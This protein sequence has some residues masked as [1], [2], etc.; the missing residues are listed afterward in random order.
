MCVVLLYS[1]HASILQTSGNSRLPSRLWFTNECRLPVQK[2]KRFLRILHKYPTLFN[3]VRYEKQRAI[4]RKTLKS[5]LRES[6]RRYVHT[7]DTFPA[8]WRTIRYIQGK[9]NSLS[10]P[11]PLKSGDNIIMEIP[12]MTE[13]IQDVF[14]KILLQ[15]TQNK[16]PG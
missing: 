10:V 13:T 15:I 14:Q 16:L 8:E 7:L 1:A 2:R 3:I 12:S 11:P 5:V 6:R 9:W 4:T